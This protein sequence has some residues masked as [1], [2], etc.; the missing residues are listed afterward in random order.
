MFSC[1]PF[2][3]LFCVLFQLVGFGF[4]LVSLALQSNNLIVSLGSVACC[5]NR[6]LSFRR[7]WFLSRCAAG[8]SGLEQNVLYLMPN[9][10]VKGT[11]RRSGW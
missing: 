9:K 3:Y 1:M 8:C 2:L 6:L 10:P 11:A 5:R 7:G 4:V